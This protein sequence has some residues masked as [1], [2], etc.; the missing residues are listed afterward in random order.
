MFLMQNTE[1]KVIFLALV[2]VTHYCRIFMK[3]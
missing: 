2:I 1:E 3:K